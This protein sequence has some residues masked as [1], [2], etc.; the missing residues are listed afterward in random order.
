MSFFESDW[1]WILILL[2][3]AVIASA[4]IFVVKDEYS[5]QDARMQA[6]VNLLAAF[7]G[8]IGFAVHLSYIFF[9][10]WILVGLGGAVLSN[11]TQSGGTTASSG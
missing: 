3:Y 9:A 1:F 8:V 4:A 11:F 6:V 10:G 5:T 2:S 7:I